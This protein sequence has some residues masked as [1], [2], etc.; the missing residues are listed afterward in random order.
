MNTGL[1]FMIYQPVFSTGVEKEQEE[2]W[3]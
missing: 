1:R 2:N 3:K